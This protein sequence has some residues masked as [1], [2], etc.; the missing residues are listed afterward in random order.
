MSADSRSLYGHGG[1]SAAGAAS[2]PLGGAAGY[3]ILG[4]GPTVPSVTL[5][6]SAITGNVGSGIVG[7]G[8][9]LTSSTVDGN[10]NA[11]VIVNTTS[12]VTGTG[13][14]DTAAFTSFLAA[15]T[16]VAATP[17]PVLSH[18]LSGSL[19]GVTLTPGV[20][21]F[22]GAATLAGT[23]TLDAQGN[24]NATWTFL[25]GTWP[26]NAASTG[27]LTATDFTV[28][29]ANG[30]NPGNVTWWVAQAVTLT[31]ADIPGTILAGAAI[32]FTGTAGAP[33]HFYGHAFAKNAVTITDYVIDASTTT[34]VGGGGHGNPG[35]DCDRDKDKDRNHYGK[36]HK[37]WNGHDRDNDRHDGRDK[38][39]H[40]RDGRW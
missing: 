16:A 18:R 28:V 29:M 31:R 21:S 39:R 12:T 35:K 26:H 14:S 27:A 40:G 4:G 9:T 11:D 34:T 38:D 6:T 1:V 7:G 8:A 19:S 15:Y 24:A 25:I 2:T 23:L 30:G 20:Y 36:H 37:W 13:P 32:T 5:T 22:N 3:A 10:V 33:N 17:I